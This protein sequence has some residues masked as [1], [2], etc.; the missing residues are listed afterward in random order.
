MNLRHKRQRDEQRDGVGGKTTA[1]IISWE[2]TLRISSASED[3]FLAFSE[4]F[5]VC[6]HRTLPPASF[7]FGGERR[8][9]FSPAVSM[10]HLPCLN[11]WQ[12]VGVELRVDKAKIWEVLVP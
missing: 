1:A 7:I 12:V 9:V 5:E 8:D 11:G 4:L 10:P 2:G 3:P 6:H